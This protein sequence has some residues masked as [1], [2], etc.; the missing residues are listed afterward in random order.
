MQPRVVKTWDELP[1]VVQAHGEVFSTRV[2]EKQYRD[3]QTELETLKAAVREYLKRPSGDGAPIRQSM[4]KQLEE[5]L[6][7]VQ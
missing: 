1:P 5:L 6:V 2:L 4:R 7:G 3:I